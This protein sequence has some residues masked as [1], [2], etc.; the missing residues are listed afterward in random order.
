MTRTLFGKLFLSYVA[1]VLTTL[2]VVGVVLPRLFSDYYFSAKEA[3]LVRKGQEIARVMEL[4]GGGQLHPPDQIW[5]QAMDQFLDARLLVVDA[6]GLILATTSQRTPRGMRLAPGE[7]AGCL[8]GQIVRSLGFNPRFGE[9]ML[10]VAI[11]LE[12]GGQV[13]GGLVLNAP[14]TGLNATVSSV[15]RLIF[16][17]AGGAIVLAGVVGYLLS[18]SISR[19]LREM[20]RTALEMA[21]G[22]FRQRL[23]VAR[24]DEVG[25]LAANF[26]HLAAAL[27]RT[28]TALADEKARI[29]N[30]LSNMAEGV[31]ATD[32]EGE[33]VMINHRARYLLKIGEEA[34]G[35]PV[36]ELPDAAA[37]ADLVSGV[38]A[39]G[40]PDAVEFDTRD[41]LLV[42]HASALSGCGGS[43]SGVVVVLQDVTELMRL[44]QLRRELLADVSHELRTPLTSIQG[45]VEALRDR[46]VDDEDTR[47]RYLAT[48]HEET[49]RLNRLIRDLLDLSLMQSGGTRW[50]VGPVD[51]RPLVERVVASFAPRITEGGIVSRVSI[52]G[53][54]LLVLGNE[55][56]LEQALTNLVA[57]AVQFTPRGGQVEVFAERQGTRVIIGVR[58][59]GPGIP[60]EDLPRIWERFYRVDK[61]RTRSSG[62]AGLGLAI[63]KQIVEAHGG[64]VSVQSRPGEGS[65]FTL[66]LPAPTFQASL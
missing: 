35:R 55:D 3:E 8:R 37:L 23:A 28:V 54:P 19:P 39:S 51:V 2:A 62:G 22:N 15:R 20:S 7:G 45:F 46:V 56:R 18:R 49:V 64:T 27:D 25:Q 1:V 61:S 43:A 63:V 44:E 11:P 16:Y 26:N 42:A 5:L 10:S 47:D 40:T 4:F 38:L 52:P 32:S 13:V 34:I 53:D 31:L 41:A 58:D 9:E 65:L 60:P 12:A 29:E 36:G 59:T 6:S 57:N 21:R 17:A 50:P 24:D 33:L 14:L 30:I 48:I 66:A